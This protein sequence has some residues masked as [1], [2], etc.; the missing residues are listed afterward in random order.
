MSAGPRWWWWWW[1]APLLSVSDQQRHS[2]HGN[3]PPVHSLFN[4]AHQTKCVL[5][6]AS[7]IFFLSF[8]LRSLCF[9]SSLPPSVPPSIPPS[10]PPSL[11]LFLPPLP[12]SLG[13]SSCAGHLLRSCP[14]VC[15]MWPPVINAVLHSVT[16][17]NYVSHALTHSKW[18][19]LCDCEKK[20]G[21]AEGP[22]SLLRPLRP[23][24]FVRRTLLS[25]STATLTTAL[26]FRQKL[27]VTVRAKASRKKHS[28][29]HCV[30]AAVS[31]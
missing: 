20:T 25:L 17:I 11:P 9:L 8:L 21:G 5:L 28:Y 16:A 30:C 22:L 3:W 27:H 4:I 10:L 13:S 14:V 7:W 12:P 2:N 23:F 6:S 24:S 1:W 26:S 15:Q 18:P 29:C 19:P 31:D